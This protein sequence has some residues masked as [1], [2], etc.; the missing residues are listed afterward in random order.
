MSSMMHAAASLS[1]LEKLLLDCSHE[2]DGDWAR[3]QSAPL[4]SS[5]LQHAQR[6]RVL[7]VHC[8]T[9]SF[10]AQL[11]SLQHLE[12]S[13]G[14]GTADID[15][16]TLALTPNLVTLHVD[17]VRLAHEV[18]ILPEHLDFR[19][20]SKLR[21]VCLDC[22]V[23]TQLSLPE[24]CSLAVEMDGL[25]LARAEVWDSVRSHICSFTIRAG[26]VNLTALADLPAVLL[27]R[28]PLLQLAL[29]FL[30]VGT[31]ES[32][33][34]LSKLLAQV[35]ALKLESMRGMYL[36]V[37]EE[38][39]WQHLV[40]TAPQQLQWEWLSA[41]GDIVPWLPQE[42]PFES[43]SIEFGSLLGTGVLE[44][45]RECTQYQYGRGGKTHICMT[46]PW[47]KYR[48]CHQWECCCRACEDC[49]WN[50]W[51]ES[52]WPWR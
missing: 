22:V 35:P 40:I 7:Q 31:A 8:H 37:P 16:S 42:A 51:H 20:L 36:L 49:L 6:L 43:L 13:L 10:P 46:K 32:P 48:W 2:L 14:G 33:L 34:Q 9:F 11:C 26:S 19:P 39:S 50:Y 52:I 28:P 24:Q 4:L 18:R 1:R 23:P 15:L 3:V 41:S 44:L 25:E 12:L 30:S 21:A 45:F 38:A 27:R 17:N 29:K 47:S 5:V